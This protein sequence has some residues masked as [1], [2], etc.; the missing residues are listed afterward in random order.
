MFLFQVGEDVL[1]TVDRLMT[2]SEKEAHVANV[3]TKAA[4]R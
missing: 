4:N 2:I 1:K 3:E